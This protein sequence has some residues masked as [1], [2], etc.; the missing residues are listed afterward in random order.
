MSEYG[1]RLNFKKGVAVC[2]ESKEKYKLAKGKVI[3][4]K[5]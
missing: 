3:K 5:H 2:P 1:H 4:I